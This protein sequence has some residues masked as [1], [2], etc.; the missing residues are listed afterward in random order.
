MVDKDSVKK[1][2]ASVIGEKYIIPTLGIWDKFEDID[3]AGLPN[4]FVLKCTHDSGGEY[5]KS[6]SVE[7]QNLLTAL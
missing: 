2:V 5:R 1:Y 6:L 7:W 3:F 4:Q